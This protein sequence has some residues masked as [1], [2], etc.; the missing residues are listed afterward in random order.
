MTCS[1]CPT[2]VPVVSQE[3]ACHLVVLMPLDKRTRVAVKAMEWL[4]ERHEGLSLYEGVNGRQYTTEERNAIALET[5]VVAALPCPFYAPDKLGRCVVG[6]LGKRYNSRDELGKAPYG[7][8]PAMLMRMIDRPGY[9]TLVQSRT[10]ADAKVAMVT[11]NE[12]L[13]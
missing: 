3:L 9:R 10:V 5:P 7:F 12:G 8:L 13:V 4:V 11:R 6:G 2:N 1:G